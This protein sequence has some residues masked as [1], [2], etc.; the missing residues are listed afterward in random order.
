MP[1]C[2]ADPLCNHASSINSHLKDRGG[3]GSELE[4]NTMYYSPN[5]SYYRG[6]AQ[7]SIPPQ[8][9]ISTNNKY[10]PDQTHHTLILGLVDTV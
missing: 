10:S 5:I 8:N 1:D 7:T 3:K 4:D 2:G 9:V 6:N